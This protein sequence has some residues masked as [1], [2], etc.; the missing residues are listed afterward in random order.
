VP[1]GLFPNDPKTHA[2]RAPI[3]PDKRFGSNPDA[4]TSKSRR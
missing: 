1:T 3:D 4:A 2:E